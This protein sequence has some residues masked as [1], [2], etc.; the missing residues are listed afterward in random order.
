MT[1]DPRAYLTT[2]EVAKRYGL[3]PRTVKGWRKRKT[4]PTWYMMSALGRP[5]NTPLV[6][7]PMEDLL[8]WEK[9][10]Q[11]VPHE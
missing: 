5:T 7:Y 11:I 8:I 1:N 2:N 10:H 4:G 9:L 3:K 6:R